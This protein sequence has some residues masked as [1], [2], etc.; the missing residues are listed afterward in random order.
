MASVETI[1]A[2]HGGVLNDL[3][4][5]VGTLK[6]KLDA[7]SVEANARAIDGLRKSM[8][9]NRT[10][11]IDLTKSVESLKNKTANLEQQCLCR[12]CR[13]RPTVLCVTCGDHL[14]CGGCDRKT[15]TNTDIKHT[16]K[17]F[18]NSGS[19]AAPGSR[20]SEPAKPDDRATKAAAE[21]AAR[22]LHELTEKVSALEC[23]IEIACRGLASR[24][25]S[26]VGDLQKQLAELSKSVS[27]LKTAD[28]APKAHV[29]V[30]A[31]HEFSIITFPATVGARGRAARAHRRDGNSRGAILIW[32]CSLDKD[33][34]CAHRL[35]ASRPSCGVSRRTS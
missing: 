28:L 2:E 6:D 3:G 16:R 17:S 14:L 19:S 10:R 32:F 7:S 5:L 9:E 18:L 33:L 30:R 27:E 31:R 25:D 4:R 34:L 29:Q 13:E 12:N 23:Q 35:K 21:F 26:R 20:E 1:S 11:S 24:V 15:H 22:K 8:E